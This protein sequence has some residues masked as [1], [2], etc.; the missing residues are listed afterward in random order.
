[1]E[2]AELVGPQGVGLKVV[3]MWQPKPLVPG[4]QRRLV[5]E[6]E[7]TAAQARGT[8]LLTLEEAGGPRILTVRGVTFP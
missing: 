1:V 3:R 5:V 2:G 4:A 6:A 7:A 8:F